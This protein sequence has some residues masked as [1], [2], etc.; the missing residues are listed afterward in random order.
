LVYK[1]EG[2]HMVEDNSEVLGTCSQVL[3][4]KNKATQIVK[5]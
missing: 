1:S 5:C 3:W 4:V 2:T